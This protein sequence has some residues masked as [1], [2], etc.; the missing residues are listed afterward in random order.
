MNPRRAST[1]LVSL[2]LCTVLLVV[3]LGFLAQRAGQYR[4]ANGSILRVRAYALADAGLEDAYQ[5]LCKDARFPP[6]NSDDQEEFAYSEELRDAGNR[7]VGSYLVR[8]D[9]RYRKNPYLIYLITSVGMVGSSTDPEARGTRTA[10]LDISPRIRGTV[11]PNP[12]FYQIRYV[13][14]GTGPG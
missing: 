12:F 11:N 3:G 6:L 5:K 2:M 10:E 4:A 8:I 1:L 7:V 9:L 14:S 13:T